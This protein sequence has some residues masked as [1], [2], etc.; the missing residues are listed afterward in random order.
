MQVVIRQIIE[1]RPRHR[2]EQIV[3]RRRYVRFQV[4]EISSRVQDEEKLLQ[5][6]TR[7]PS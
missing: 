1:E 6:V 7:R 5:G 4:L 2:L 3:F